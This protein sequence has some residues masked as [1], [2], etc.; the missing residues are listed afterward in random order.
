MECYQSYWTRGRKDAPEEKWQPMLKFLCDEAKEKAKKGNVCVGFAVY[1]R[2]VR[3][4]IKTHIPNVVFIEV[5]VPLETLVE[6]NVIRSTKFCEEN[7]M[8]MKQLWEV[9]DPMYNDIRARF[10]QEYSVE[11]FKKSAREGFLAGFEGLDEDEIRAGCVKIDNS[12]ASEQGIHYLNKFLKINMKGK[13]DL[14]AI[15]A[16]QFSRYKD[17]ADNN[18][19]A[20]KLENYEK[21]EIVWVLGRAGAGKTFFC[22]YL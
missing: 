15:E 1:N 19:Y 14:K 16:V 18:N 20:E 22:D 12:A 11:T 6:R 13:I 21:S 17:A 10:G 5:D 7:G 8:T 3:D 2:I 4:Y 9:D